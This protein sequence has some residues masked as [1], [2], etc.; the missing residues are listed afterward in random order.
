VLV[1]EQ[2]VPLSRLWCEAVLVPSAAP[3]ARL[4]S[5]E[6]RRDVVRSIGFQ[7]TMPDGV[8][9]ARGDASPPQIPARPAGVDGKCYP[10]SRPRASWIMDAAAHVRQGALSP[11]VT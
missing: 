11:L 2:A 8:K 5:K 4:C 7:E 9:K 1:P 3:K 10:A 6:V